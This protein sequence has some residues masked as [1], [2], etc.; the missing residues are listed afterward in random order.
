MTRLPPTRLLQAAAA[1]RTGLQRLT[2]RMVP[3]EVALLELTTGFIATRTVYAAAE[4]GL[5]DAL[6]SGP[7]T[8]ADLATDLG[9]DPDATH[10]LLR[11]CAAWGVFRQRRDGRFELTPAADRLRAGT[12]GSMREV[13]RMLGH[14]AYQR[15]W[16]ELAGSVRTGEAGAERA[17]GSSMWDYLE[18]DRGFG[19]TFDAAMT[20]LSALDWPM[21]EAV[22][23]FSRFRVIADVGGGHGQLLALMLG[24]APEARG[25]LL[26]Q[27]SMTAGAQELLAREGVL[28]RCEVRAGSF[29]ETAPDDADLYVLRRVLHDHDDERAAAVLTTLRGHM[30]P[31]ATLLVMEGVVPAGNGPH[32]SKALDLDMLVFVGGRERTEAQW[33]ALLTSTGFEPPRIVPTLSSVSLVESTPRRSP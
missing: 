30:P 23:D 33:H 10:R 11:A 16:G 25:I 14:P 2:G 19:E 9:T 15:V 27:A 13:V 17:L 21:V 32:L 20:R 31:G 18:Q 8:S 22:Y 12:P 24:A 7:R 4:V 1:A 29:F 3:P 28:E 5:A 26:E 6:A